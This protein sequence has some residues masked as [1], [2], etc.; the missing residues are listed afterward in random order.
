MTRRTLLAASLAARLRADSADDA[1]E[2]ITSAAR[3]LTEATSLPPP[4]RGTAAAFLDYFD[5]KMSGYE[6]LRANAM[7]LVAQADLRSTIDL[8]S[9]E[10][11]DRSREM[12]LDWSLRMVDPAT[13]IT[14]KNREEHVKCRVEKQGKK[15]RIVAFEPLALFA[16]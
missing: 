10:G 12:E 2:V 6:T 16:P 8:V 4:N 1:W 15:W 3:A 14:S 9:N 13:G 11:G 5:R 7:A